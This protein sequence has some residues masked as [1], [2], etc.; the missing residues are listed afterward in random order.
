[1]FVRTCVS[2]CVC[3]IVNDV[4]FIHGSNWQEYINN[5]SVE[6]F[7]ISFSILIIV[8]MFTTHIITKRYTVCDWVSS[9]TSSHTYFTYQHNYVQPE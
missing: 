7:S 3:V 2:A 8:I 6:T 4:P 1:M 9:K 5:Y